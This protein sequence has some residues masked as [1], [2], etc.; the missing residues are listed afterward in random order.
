MYRL[1]ILIICNN[2]VSFS[3]WRETKEEM[4]LGFEFTFKE[5]WLGQQKGDLF[6]SEKDS[7]KATVV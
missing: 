5:C 6:C 1:G 3:S 7:E 4:L 2:F